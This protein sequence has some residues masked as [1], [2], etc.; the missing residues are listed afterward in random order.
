MTYVWE[1]SSQKGT[2]L[3]L[4]LAVADF[5]DKDGKAYPSIRTLANRI[6]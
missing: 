5:A 3:L 2:L 4:L 6:P 1:H